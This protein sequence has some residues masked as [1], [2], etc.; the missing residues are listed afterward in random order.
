M[1][2]HLHSQ[3]PRVHDDCRLRL[4]PAVPTTDRARVGNPRPAKAW[5]MWF[6]TRPGCK[7]DSVLFGRPRCGRHHDRLSSIHFYDSHYL[8]Q[9]LDLKPAPEFEAWLEKNAYQMQAVCKPAIPCSPMSPP[10]FLSSPDPWAY[11]RCYN[12]RIAHRHR[13]HRRQPDDIHHSTSIYTPGREMWCTPPL[14]PGW[15]QGAA[16]RSRAYRR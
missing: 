7:G 4:I 3:R 13:P 6:A 11:L 9:A 10:E 16:Q 2:H 14:I 1:D 12:A 8:R 5:G 15:S